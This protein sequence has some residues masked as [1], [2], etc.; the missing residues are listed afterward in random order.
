MGSDQ[1]LIQTV[2]SLHPRLFFTVAMYTYERDVTIQYYPNPNP[3]P[4]H[5]KVLNV[6][7]ETLTLL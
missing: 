1:D 4:N 5:K 2:P 6:G 7:P 3:N